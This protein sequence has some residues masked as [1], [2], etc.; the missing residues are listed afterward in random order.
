MKSTLEQYIEPE[1]IPKKYGGQL[2][3]KFGDLPNLDATIQKSLTWSSP[4]KEGGRDTFPTGPIRWQRYENGD[5]AAIAVGSV[6]GKARDT[7]VAVL[8]PSTKAV[9]TSLGAGHQG[10]QMFRT[11]SGIDTHPATPPDNQVDV[12]ESSREESPEG[13]VSSTSARGPAPALVTGAVT[14]IGTGASG[15]TYLSYQDVALTSTTTTLPHHGGPPAGSETYQESS[16]EEAQTHQPSTDREG[17]S[18]TRYAEQSNTHAQGTLSEGTPHTKGSHGDTYSV[19][20]PNTV[21]QAPKE[22]PLPPTEEPAAPS[23]LDQAKSLAGQAYGTATS[24]GTS[25][26][27]AVGVGGAKEETAEEKPK[28]TPHDPAVDAAEPAQVEAFLRAKYSS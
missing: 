21:G 27:A 15:G 13:R 12:M 2:D 5:L 18:T 28:T 14:A 4:A 23:Y 10:H 7:K 3:Y 25:A 16:F 24:V 9:Q 26:L 19:M 20:E 17:T 11:T 1:N 6:K 8:H 22:Y